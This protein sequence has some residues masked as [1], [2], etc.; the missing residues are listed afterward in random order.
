MSAPNLIPVYLSAEDWQEV[1]GMLQTDAES[2]FYAEFPDL[3]AALGRA[4]AG[5]DTALGNTPAPAKGGDA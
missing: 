1:A 2:D 3:V 5:I 4:V